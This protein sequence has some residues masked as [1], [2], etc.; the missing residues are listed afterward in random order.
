MLER[1]RAAL[2]EISAEL[3]LAFDEQDLDYYT[4]LFTRQMRRNPTSVELFDIGQS[5]SEHSRHWFFG[6]RLVIDGEAMP[7]TLFQLV[8][9]P[10]KV[11]QQPVVLLSSVFE[12]IVQCATLY[13]CTLI[14]FTLTS[15]LVCLGCGPPVS[16]FS[17]SFHRKPLRTR[18]GQ[19]GQLDDR[20]CR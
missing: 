7:H 5:N 13:N 9:Q 20:V 15:L 11:R 6:G 12:Q 18:A 19:S 1:G 8:K 17:L 10:W 2:Q 3:G 4:D 14:R 16:L